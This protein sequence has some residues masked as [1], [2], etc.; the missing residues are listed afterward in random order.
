MNNNNTTQPKLADVISEGDSFF[1]SYYKANHVIIEV[2]AFQCLGISVKA[3]REGPHNQ[4]SVLIFTPTCNIRIAD[5]TK[6]YYCS[7]ALAGALA[8]MSELSL[9]NTDHSLTQE[10]KDAFFKATTD[11]LCRDWD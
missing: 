1:V 9:G 3:R 4:W 6:K 2:T 11:Y 8:A 7:S 10:D 5:P